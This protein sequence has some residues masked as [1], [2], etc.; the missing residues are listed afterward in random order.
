MKKFPERI[1]IYILIALVIFNLYS[2]ASAQQTRAELVKLPNE[3]GK[4][5]NIQLYEGSYALLI[6]S[7]KYTNGWNDLPGVS[8]DLIEVEKALAKQHFIVEKLIDPTSKNL[9]S[10]IDLFVKNYGLQTNNRLLIYFAGHG[11]TEM[12]DDG[13]KFGYIVPVDAPMPKKDLLGFRQTAVTMDEMESIARKIRSKHALFVFDSCFSGTLLNARRGTIPPVIS[14]KAAQP[15][16]QFI[17][18]GAAD[19]EVP[20]ESIFRR[21]FV[22]G[23]G[24]EADW[25]GDGYVTGIELAEFLKEKVTNYTRG[26]QTPLYGKIFDQALDKGDFIFIVGEQSKRP[27][28]KPIVTQSEE[29]VP[30]RIETPRKQQVQPQTLSVS[31]F[32]KT[33]VCVDDG[34]AVSVTADGTISL[35]PNIKDTNPVGKDSFQ[36]FLGL[37]LPIDKQ[38]YIEQDFPL[39]A[40]LCRF[41]YSEKWNYCSTSRTFTAEKKGCLILEVNDKDKSDNRGAYR[42]NI[43]PL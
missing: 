15:V 8:D 36:T 1:C 30:P 20:D 33:D 43:K 18:A 4:T 27:P 6:G 9:L 39:G 31:G 35:G 29:R 7:S 12:G 13:R 26:S 16:R 42:V 19:Q 5:E 28:R 3:N 14:I 34:T 21:Q 41:D 10:T 17:T 37:T 22:E 40:L 25:N 24:G 32:T 11:F 38:Y 2:I 23:I